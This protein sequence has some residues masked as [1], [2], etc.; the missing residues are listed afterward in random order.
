V[1]E[2]WDAISRGSSF[3]RA[4]II[5]SRMRVLHLISCR[6]IKLTLAHIHQ[7]VGAH[8]HEHI[9]RR[10][11]AYAVKSRA[12]TRANSL[13]PALFG[14]A[15]RRRIERISYC[16]M[17]SAVPPLR[18]APLSYLFAWVLSF[19]FTPALPPSFRIRLF[20]PLSPSNHSSR[21]SSSSPL[22]PLAPTADT[23]RAYACVHVVL[24]YLLHVLRFT[25]D[26]RVL[27]RAV[28]YRRPSAPIFA[29]ESYREIS[30][31]KFSEERASQWRDL[32]MLFPPRFLL[33]NLAHYTTHVEFQ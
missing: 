21:T 9:S 12:C 19:S 23:G 25:T 6:Y 26:T 8:V 5:P 14:T 2:R 1:K 18:L 22:L 16:R 30:F 28:A 3:A 17:Q 4:C 29:L 15:K 10:V 33:S 7:A 32:C 31:G 13:P 20:S 11:V 24:L 27:L